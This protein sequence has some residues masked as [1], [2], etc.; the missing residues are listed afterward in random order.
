[1]AAM[2]TIIAIFIAIILLLLFLY[3]AK[4]STVLRAIKNHVTFN[5]VI[6][7]LKKLAEILNSLVK[8]LII[9]KEIFEI[10]KKLKDIWTTQWSYLG[11]TSKASE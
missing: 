10:I 11:F 1:M 5:K 6:Y 3:P 8:V 9:V 2:P 4:I 7:F